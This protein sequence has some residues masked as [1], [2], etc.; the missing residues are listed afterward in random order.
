[1]LLK[2]ARKQRASIYHHATI[3]DL[4]FEV[5]RESFLYLEPADLVSPSRANRSWRPTAQDVQQS[6]FVVE[7]EDYSLLCGIQLTRIAFGYDAY[8][9]KH[10]V[11][12][13]YSV[14]RNYIP[15][16]ARLVSPTLRTLD[17]DYFGVE[18]SSHYVALDQFF[19]QCDGIRNLKLNYFDF[20]DN[21]SN[22]SQT[23]KEGFYQLSQLSLYGCFGDLRMFVVSVPIPNL[24]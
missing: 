17:L 16:L 3:D 24:L 2:Y 21:P 6:R 14:N 5:L 1:M 7:K 13:L 15:I 4:P 10:L 23:I 20:G 12:D 9:I 8:S 22:I 11:I 19:S 18:T